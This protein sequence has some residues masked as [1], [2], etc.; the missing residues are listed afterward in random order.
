M[1]EDNRPAPRLP[2]DIAVVI[3]ILEGSLG[4]TIETDPNTGPFQ[5]AL[6]QTQTPLYWAASYDRAIYNTELTDLFETQ[7]A[8]E[9]EIRPV[10][11]E[12]AKPVPRP[13]QF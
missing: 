2:L 5:N 9:D 8:A 7:Q 11:V 13:P 1:T 4:G 3:P 6:L 10:L 12:F